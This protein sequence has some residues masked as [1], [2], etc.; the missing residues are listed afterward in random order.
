MIHLLWNQYHLIFSL[1]HTTPPTSYA[2]DHAHI[3]M[4]DDITVR[5][6]TCLPEDIYLVAFYDNDDVFMFL[7]ISI[8][9]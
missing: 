2:N 4:A 3:K 5:K 9:T 1:R 6:A 7:L 8:P